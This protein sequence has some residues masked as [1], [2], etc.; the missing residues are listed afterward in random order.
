MCKIHK[1]L[2]PIGEPVGVAIENTE[3]A[4]YLGN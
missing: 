3:S 4:A 2:T 1:M